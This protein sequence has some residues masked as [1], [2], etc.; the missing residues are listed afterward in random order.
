MADLIGFPLD[1]EKAV[2]LAARRCGDFPGSAVVTLNTP[3]GLEEWPLA[4][5]EHPIFS[6]DLA[7]ASDP[8]A[9]EMLALIDDGAADF[10]AGETLVV[11][12]KAPRFRDM[13]APD[14][15]PVAAPVA[16]VAAL[17]GDL[18]TQGKRA[19][20]DRAEME[21]YSA[22]YHA[23]EFRGAALARPADAAFHF[24]RYCL[25]A[26]GFAGAWLRLLWLDHFG[27]PSSPQS[28]ET[29]MLSGPAEPVSRKDGDWFRAG[30]VRGMTASASF[31]QDWD[32]FPPDDEPP[33]NSPFGGGQAA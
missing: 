7:P 4:A 11:E 19:A 16:P 2:R 6:E 3:G 17:T 14:R 33:H 9:G 1:M 18:V 21:R 25:A 20:I 10:V 22:V 31:P 8:A 12:T 27:A 13:A 23:T 28:S 29:R 30:C 24:A 15:A 5:F 32:D 26:A